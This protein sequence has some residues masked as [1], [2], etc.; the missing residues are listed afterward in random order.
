MSIFPFALALSLICQ[1]P[2]VSR[3]EQLGKMLTGGKLA[4]AERTLMAELAAKPDDATRMTLGMTKFL[5]AIEDH[6]RTLR[7]FGLNG[8]SWLL[9]NVPFLR[10]P[11]PEHPNPVAVRPD[12]LRA[13]LDKM[14]KDL[15]AAEA[16][17]APIKSADWKVVVKV[18]DIKLDV[19]DPGEAPQ[20]VSLAEL[21]SVAG[22]APRNDT[23]ARAAGVVVAFDK[24]DAMWLRGYCRFLQSLAEV[25][26]AYDAREL[27]DHTAHLAFAKP[28]GKFPFLKGKADRRDLDSDSIIDG[29]T[30]IHMLRVP[31]KDPAR[32]KSAHGHLLEMFE[33][34]GKM[35]E[36]IL[37]E[38]D[39]DREWIP[40]P[41]QKGAIP[42][43]AV[44]QEMVTS[45]R[46]F[47]GE[48][49]DL[50]EGRKL[51]PF[52]RDG[53]EAKAVRGVNI[54]RVFLEPGP[55]DLVLWVQGT[56]AVPYL[57]QGVTTRPDTWNRFSQ[58][59]QGRFM[60]FFVWWN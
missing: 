44:T 36:E 39:S 51:A 10:I 53:A 1:A 34:S 7:R 55:F 21:L 52:W 30:F 12:D 42:G 28:V 46:E 15:D 45:W 57:E 14:V 35:W 25:V 2:D 31:V 17:L 8:K 37:A 40:A 47:V 5:R 50:L 16:A 11:V 9:Q 38:T 18:E 20:L 54:K 43:I 6:A 49:K 22:F 59:F 33:N 29:I 32:L 4:D 41:K 24:S 23:G 26:L 48:V 27:F 58:V 60:T 13:A 56:A 3:Q 19:A